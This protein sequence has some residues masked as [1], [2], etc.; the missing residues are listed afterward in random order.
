MITLAAIV[1]ISAPV[2]TFIVGLEVLRRKKKK[3][4]PEYSYMYP[5]EKCVWVYYV[6][7]FGT[8]YQPSCEVFWHID[9]KGKVPEMENC[10]Y[11]G[12]RLEIKDFMEGKK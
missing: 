8:Y 4:K 2:I 9:E 6:E 7:A 1:I 5:Q 10:R 12:G 3:A 11:C